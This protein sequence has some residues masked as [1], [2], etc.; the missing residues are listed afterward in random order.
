MQK[1]I[2]T[3]AILGIAVI[4]IFMVT[5]RESTTLGGSDTFSDATVATKNIGATLTSAVG[6]NAQRKYFSI[7]NHSA[8]PIFCVLDGS[9]EASASTVTSTPNR[10][11]GFRVAATSTANDS[12]M[13]EIREYV[14]NINCTASAGTTSTVITSP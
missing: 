12:S 3:I 9:T 6:Q 2:N 1:L 7:Q 8:I 4:A 14:G 11:V 5:N 10:E 13:W